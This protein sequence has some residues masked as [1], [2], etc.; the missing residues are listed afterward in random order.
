LATTLVSSVLACIPP[1]EEPDKFLAVLKL[2]GSSFCLVGIGVV[3]YWLGRR[4]N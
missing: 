1:A 2:L 4:K 3:S